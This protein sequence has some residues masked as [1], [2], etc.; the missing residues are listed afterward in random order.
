[1]S[2]LAG[3]LLLIVGLALVTGSP[4]PLLVGGALLVIVPEIHALARRRKEPR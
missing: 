2:Q 1:M 4:L 3:L